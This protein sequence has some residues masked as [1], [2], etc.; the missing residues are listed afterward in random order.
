MSFAETPYHVRPHNIFNS[1][2][3]LV[4]PHWGSGNVYHED[5]DGKPFYDFT[6]ADQRT[7]RSSAPVTMPLV[8]LAFTP[9]ALVPDEAKTEL[10]VREQPRASTARTR[11]GWW[12]YPP[13][14]YQKWGGLVAAL[15]EH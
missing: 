11:P 14:D 13:K 5:A 9:L 8:E 4:L 2:T 3:G 15:V 6:I 7:T 10:P 12:S 1:G